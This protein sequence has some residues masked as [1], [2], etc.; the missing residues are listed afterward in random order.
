MKANCLLDASALL[1]HLF[2]E[3]GGQHVVDRIAEASVTSVNW[4]ETLQHAIDRDVEL[5]GLTDELESLGMSIIPFTA[6]HA[7]E[8]AQMRTPTRH[9]GLSLADRACLAVA[10]EEG[11]PVLTAD[12]SW[13]QL[14]LGI[15]IE[16]IR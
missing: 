10:S 9:L 6:E 16:L 7:L 2:D 5:T 13:A 4:S 3:P 8:T 15:E 14:D 12:R 11:L 1:A